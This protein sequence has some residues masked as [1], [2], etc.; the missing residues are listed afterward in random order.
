MNDQNSLSDNGADA[1]PS[2]VDAAVIALICKN[3]ELLMI[4]RA[5]SLTDRWS[6]HIA[7]PGGRLRP[8]E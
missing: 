1:P 3:S 2:K 6:S 4:K 5:N 7:F 8:G